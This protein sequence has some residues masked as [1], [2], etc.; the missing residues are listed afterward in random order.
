MAAVTPIET[1]PT[2]EVRE[3][4]EQVGRASRG[5]GVLNVFKVMALSPDLMRV[6]WEMMTAL[7]TRLSL[8]P[9]LR[10]L[11]VLRLFQVLR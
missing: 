10:E 8:N 3:F 7:F 1:P 4:Y 9:R 2:Q 11:A 6:W 5:L